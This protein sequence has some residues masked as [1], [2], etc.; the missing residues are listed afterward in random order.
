MLE[1]TVSI[2]TGGSS[3]IGRSIAERYTDEGAEV[4]IASRSRDECRE[5]ADEIGCDYTTCDVSVY[6]QVE[7]A[8]EYTVER[9]GRLD[10]V[11]NNAGIYQAGTVEETD[12]DDWR[13]IMEVNLDGVM[14]GS[15]ASVP[16]LRQTEGC[17]INIA[18]VYGV[19]G[20]A[21]SAAYCAS[22][23]GVVNLTREMAV[24]YAPENV[25]VNSISPGAVETPMTE[26]KL[27][28]EEFYNQ[29]TR[30]TPLGRIAQPEEIAGAAAFLASEDASYVTGANIPVDGGWTSH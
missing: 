4:V 13:R 7:D 24:D 8:V 21:E 5:A 23:G 26:D 17:I 22:K 10:V 27:E 25:R 6:S 15:K 19:V 12:I 9:H 29:I 16:Y 2:V 3:G 20:G 11:V 18:S 28:D 30:E 14:H 1:D